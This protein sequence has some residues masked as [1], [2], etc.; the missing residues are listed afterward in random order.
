MLPEEEWVDWV[1]VDNRPIEA[2]PRS[3]MRKERL[4]HRATY[5]FIE[6]SLGRLYVQKRTL[7]K[8]YCPGML[9][10]CCGG[11][12]QTGEAYGSSALRELAE[13]M[14]IV[15]DTLDDW[16]T[17]HFETEDNRVWG[18]IY[19]CVYQGALKLQ[20][21]EVEAVYLMRLDEIWR[22]QSEFMPDSLC[23]L[24]HWLD[25]RLSA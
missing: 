24:K 21:S 17:F 6:D 8:D 4:C 13:E 9:E 23:A 15:V 19:S 1:D 20:A 22:R 12:V 16:G 10:A 5:I 18:A 25:R 3:R 11:V 7:N 14:G 2:V